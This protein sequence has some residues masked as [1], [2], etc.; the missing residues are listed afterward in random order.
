M[1]IRDVER[2]VLAKILRSENQLYVLDTTIAQPVYLMARGNDVA[3]RWHSCLGHL[4][5]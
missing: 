5:F 3:W 2:R 4:G 1:C